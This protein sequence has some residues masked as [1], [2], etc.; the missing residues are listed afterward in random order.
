MLTK[1]NDNLHRALLETIQENAG[2]ATPGGQ[3]G[4]PIS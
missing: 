3:R 4:G 2:A 1:E